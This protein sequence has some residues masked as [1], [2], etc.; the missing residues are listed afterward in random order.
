[1]FISDEQRPLAKELSERVSREKL[2]LVR[3]AWADPHGCSRAKAVSVPVF[4]YVRY[5]LEEVQWNKKPPAPPLPPEVVRN[6]Q[7]KYLDAYKKL[8]GRNLPLE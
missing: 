6:T 7:K 4:L 8:T 5:Y 1:M 3:L 2:E